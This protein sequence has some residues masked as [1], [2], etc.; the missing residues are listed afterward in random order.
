MLGWGDLSYFFL[1]IFPKRASLMATSAS[2]SPSHSPDHWAL[3]DL[4]QKRP[5]LLSCPLGSAVHTRLYPCTMESLHGY[6]ILKE[7]IS[8][9]TFCSCLSYLNGTWVWLKVLF[10][11]FFLTS[12][13]FLSWIYLFIFG[14]ISICYFM[15]F[16]EYCYN[17]VN[18]YVRFHLASF[19]I[20][21]VWWDWRE[22]SLW[23]HEDLILAT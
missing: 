22:S 15:L 7:W 3:M 23:S 2:A 14:S 20:K 13:I 4:R 12:C 5:C 19:I 18:H 8:W 11:V 21:H 6:V 9:F 17:V 16:S 1:H 10:C